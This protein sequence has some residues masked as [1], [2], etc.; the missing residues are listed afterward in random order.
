M[1]LYVSR[2][3]ILTHLP[4]SGFLDSL[5]CVLIAPTPG[6]AFSLVMPRTLATA[7]SFSSG[8]VYISLNFLPPLSLRSIP[9]LIMFGSTSRLTTPPRCHFTMYMPHLF[10]P[11]RR[12][13][14]P[15]S[16]LP[17]FFPPPEI[18]S[19]WGTSTA[20]TPSGTQEILPTPAGRKYSTVSSLTSSPSMALT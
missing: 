8:R 15:T 9:T 12:M 3:S 2:N 14:E 13:A 11:F 18:S 4:L 19:F 7:S 10:A 1:T 17:P 5:L 20:T 6:V 16:F